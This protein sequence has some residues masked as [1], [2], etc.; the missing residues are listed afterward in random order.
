[1]VGFSN[2]VVLIGGIVTGFLVPL[3]LGVN[4]YG[5]FKIYTLYLTYT[6]LLHFGFVDGLL[7]INAGKNM[8]L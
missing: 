2:I 5:Y 7:L 8:I 6:S 1:M 4:E 3:V